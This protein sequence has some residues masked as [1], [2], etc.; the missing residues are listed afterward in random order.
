MNTRFPLRGGNWNNGANAGIGALNLNNS[1]ANANSNIGFR[2]ALDDARSNT[3]TEVCPCNL[4]KDA[5]A[6]AMAETKNKQAVATASCMFEEIF[7]F[8]NLLSAAYSCRKGKATKEATMRFFFNLEE[9]IVSLQN[10]LMWG[11]YEM[12]EYR[13]FYVFEPKRRLINAPHFRDR[14]VHR[15][16]YNVINPVIDK[17][18]IFDSYACRKNKGTHKGADRTQHFIRKTIQ[19]KGGAFSLKADIYHYFSSIDHHILKK[20]IT[21]EL[22]CGRFN[23]QVHNH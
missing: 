15:A 8:E 23:I 18:F 19:K 12:S 7:N 1:R 22:S 6:S 16:I 2:P 9:N 21:R 4:E 20:I 13:S 14:V 5:T 17:R 10:E 11:R 3:F